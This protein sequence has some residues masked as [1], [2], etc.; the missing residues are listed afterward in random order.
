MDKYIQEESIVAHIDCFDP[1]DY[2][3]DQ[4]LQ[5]F[6]ENVDALTHTE[7]LEQKLAHSYYHEPSHHFVNQL[8]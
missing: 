6:W 2:Q 5:S 8:N 7:E 3:V 4:A 1:I